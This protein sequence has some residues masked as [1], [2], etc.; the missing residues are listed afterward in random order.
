VSHTVAV[1]PEPSA[2]SEK[3]RNAYVELEVFKVEP[4]SEL[5]T[6]FY[7]RP[8]KGQ[9]VNAWEPG[10]FLPI[11]VTIPGEK[12]P[13]LRTYS[14]ST[15]PNPD[16]YR[17]SIRR[18][19]GKALV[20]QFLHANA[21]PGFRLEAAAP[22]GRFVLHRANGRTPVLISGGVGI[23]PMM[24]MVE[25]IVFE[26]RQ[27]GKFRPVY[28]IHG[29]H[30]HKVHAFSKHIRELAAQH[31]GLKVHICHSEPDPSSGPEA[32]CD[33]EGRVTIETLKQVLP[34]GDY[35]FYLCGPA[36]F[37]R[38]LYDGLTGIGV[39]EDRIHY[40]SFGPAT[41][42]KPEVRPEVEIEPG[43]ADVPPVRVRFAKSGMTAEWSRDKGTLLE[44]AESAGLTPNFG[45]RSGICGTC[46]TRIAGGAV[47]YLEEPVAQRGPGEILICCSVPH[48]DMGLATGGNE[49]EVVL[50][51]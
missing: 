18:E 14:I 23:T 26:G 20:S 25:Q 32:R 43:H 8:A 12:E 39:R 3:E 31:P 29:A 47:D 13:A 19:G 11:R 49:H 16:H 28:F 24:A 50:D 36:A 34:F 2:P 9:G 37:M 22:R 21:K 4:E 7:L 41:V 6:S 51:L 17:L 48:S 1:N 42:L 44:L 46:I 45:C 40:E 15:A 35:D 10:Q 5:I 33:S 30:N 27:T 38:S